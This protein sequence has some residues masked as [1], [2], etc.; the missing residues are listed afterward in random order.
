M[1]ISFTRPTSALSGLTVSSTLG[2]LA[3]Y[4]VGKSVY[5]L[6]R[7]VE[8]SSRG[9]KTPP[10]SDENLA[11][12]EVRQETVFLTRYPYAFPLLIIPLSPYRLTFSLVAFFSGSRG[13]L[14]SFRLVLEVRT[15]ETTQARH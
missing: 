1:L 7:V 15:S 9:H 12:S 13:C 5:E 8:T 14:F 4:V 10:G 11:G 2:Q 3:V 6:V